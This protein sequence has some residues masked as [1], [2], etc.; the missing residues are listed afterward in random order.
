MAGK[1]QQNTG[2]ETNN[3]DIRFTRY[4]METGKVLPIALRRSIAPV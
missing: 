4:T 2:A 1:G 3:K